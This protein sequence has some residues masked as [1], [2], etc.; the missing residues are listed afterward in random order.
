MRLLPTFVSA[1]AAWA[2]DYSA[3]QETKPRTRDGDR[4][5]EENREGGIVD[6]QD[7]QNLGPTRFDEPAFRKDPYPVYAWLRANSPVHAIELHRGKR[8]WLLTRFHDVQAALR[9]PRLSKDRSKLSQGFVDPLA[10][11]RLGSSMLSVDPPQ[12][13]RLRALT[14]A[15]FTRKSVQELRPRVHN[16]AE[17]LVDSLP[18]RTPFDLISNYAL[19]LPF[20][21]ICELLGVRIQDRQTF[22]WHALHV[23][24]PPPQMPSAQIAEHVTWLEEFLVQL[25]DRKRG[26]ADDDLLSRL[27]RVR[28]HDR[29]ALTEDELVSSAF[30]LITAG[31]ENTVN[32]IAN[33]VHALLRHPDQ[34]DL[35]RSDLAALLPQTVDEVLRYD[36]PVERTTTLV[37]TADLRFAGITIRTGSAVVAS[38]ASA[39]RDPA[40]FSSPNSFRIRRAEGPC[41]GFGHGVHHC[42]GAALAR[43]ETAIALDS[44]L[45][46]F[47]RITLACP[48]H[49]LRYRSSSLIR[50]LEELPVIVDRTGG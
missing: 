8:A 48:S 33:A 49:T 14:V 12:H 29:D 41:L 47:P 9:D 39:N 6:T 30:L 23:T 16:T 13:T 34:L 45:R 32:L 43:M 11:S 35:L 38:L 46:R 2:D 24:S 7:A 42:L 28:G 37:A 25:I 19:P 5:C 17:R 15:A 3:P 44:L 31:Y 18:E 20:A 27:I 10:R 21:V 22:Q 4:L 1:T 26:L 40:R 50:G 36:S